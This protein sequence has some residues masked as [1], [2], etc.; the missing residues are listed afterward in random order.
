MIKVIIIMGTLML[1][2]MLMVSSLDIGD[3]NEECA[4]GEVPMVVNNIWSC[5]PVIATGGSSLGGNQTLIYA[6]ECDNITCG[7]LIQVA[8]NEN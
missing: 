8:Q 5:S 3:I 4:E 1:A 2:A 6:N 7:T